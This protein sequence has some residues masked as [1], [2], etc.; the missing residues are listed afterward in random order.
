MT[1]LIERSPTELAI[2]EQFEI[3][4]QQIAEAVD[5]ANEATVNGP[6]DK[7]GMELASKC[8][9]GL[10]AMRVA[11]DKKGKELREDAVKRQRLVVKITKELIEPIP[12]AEARLQELEDTAKRERE[13]LEQIAADERAAEGR[14]RCDL[15]T[16]VGWIIQPGLLIAMNLADF[17]AHYEEK[18]AERE[19]AEKTK[20]EEVEALRAAKAASDK[21]AAEQKARQDELDRKEAEMVAKKKAIDDAEKSRR[22]KCLG[23][24]TMCLAK[25][26]VSLSADETMAFS[27]DEFE[28]HMTDL[29]VAFDEKQAEQAEAERIRKE[30]EAAELEARIAA[31]ANEQAERLEQERLDKIAR[32]NAKVEAARLKAER[33]AAKAPDHE[34]VIEFAAALDQLKRPTFKADDMNERLSSAIAKLERELDDMASELSE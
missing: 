17:E 13:R 5:L 29:R 24:R 32:E 4:Q 21:L 12:A 31:K 9:K 27:D 28:L 10:K 18:R 11:I 16:S 33:K 6:G 20:A 3:T 14:R 34:K 22:E 26:G 1:T 19:A 23:W 2:I 7:E 8:R 25:V 15:A 30:K